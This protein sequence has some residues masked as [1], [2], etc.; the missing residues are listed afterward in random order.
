MNPLDHRVVPLRE[1]SLRE[2]VEMALNPS[3]LPRFMVSYFI[4]LYDA[5]PSNIIALRA[6]WWGRFVEF[7]S[8]GEK[9]F[10]ILRES[11]GFQYFGHSADSSSA[12]GARLIADSM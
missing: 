1:T 2:T 8:L 12:C 11:K 3:W 9:E 7:E 6:Q 5:H 10:P 4:V